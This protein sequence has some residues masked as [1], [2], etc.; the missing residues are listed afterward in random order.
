MLNTME[1]MTDFVIL[2]LGILLVLFFIIVFIVKFIAE[3]YVPFYT[4][5]DI[6]REEIMRSHGEGRERWER[7]LKRLYAQNVPIIGGY[8]VRRIMRKKK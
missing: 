6:I 2:L 1:T 3:V 5:R 7:E 8:L 4:E